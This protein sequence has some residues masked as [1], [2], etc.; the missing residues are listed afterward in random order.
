VIPIAH[1]LH[2]VSSDAAV[3]HAFDTGS[4]AEL[5]SSAIV[6]NGTTTVIDPIPLAPDATAELT[7]NAPLGAVIVTNA[8]HHR[9]AIEWSDEFDVRIVAA[10]GA[11]DV[12]NTP[13]RS[14]EC[15]GG[16]SILN[17]FEV[18][19]I[20]GAVAGE[21]AIYRN[22]DLI[23]GD[24]LINFEPYGF[25]FL[26]QK[27]CSNFKVMKRSLRQLLDR[28]VQ[29]IFFAHGTPILSDGLARLTALL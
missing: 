15:R 27:Y 17:G 9:A 29:R 1:E 22:G 11:F 19:G 8:N 10:T 18:I 12:K 24:C 23:V 5:F 2:R 6:A 20:E 13:P 4:K 25:T 3:W 7:A 21:I 28:K 26:P 16:D 14:C